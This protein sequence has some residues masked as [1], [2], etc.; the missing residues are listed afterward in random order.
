MREYLSNYYQRCPDFLSEFARED[1]AGRIDFAKHE[2]RF[3]E[4]R[5]GQLAGFQLHAC[6]ASALVDARGTLR[7]AH[8]GL[9]LARRTKDSD[10]ISW[11]ESSIGN[12]RRILEDFEAAEKRLQK[13]RRIA[14]NVVQK[15]DSTRRFAALIFTCAKDDP[16]EIRRALKFYS[17]A[18]KFH[19]AA[20]ERV[21]SDRG[22][23]MALHDQAIAHITLGHQGY[24]SHL[25]QGK[26]DLLQV[27]RE[28]TVHS[29]RSEDGAILNLTILHLRLDQGSPQY[30]LDRL[31][32]S[33]SPKNSLR[34][35]LT[36]WALIFE[37]I[38]AH[39]Y[40]RC[41]RQRLLTVRRHLK[42]EGAW[43]YAS[44]LSLAM[45][46]LEAANE[47]PG[48]LAF[49]QSRETQEILEKGESPKFL[50]AIRGAHQMAPGA[51]V[52]LAEAAGV[53]DAYNMGIRS[54]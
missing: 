48:A 11:G 14:V 40:D 27:L 8:F 1:L 22:Y 6:D 46:A 4:P 16:K 45:A 36:Q 35:A 23:T 9:E 38:R 42:A 24:P 31:E 15:G 2:A 43:N 50:E 19:L 51:I 33:S 5:L 7:A 25:E 29:K 28:A 37:E 39:G 49:L 47:N 26:T 44:Q 54:A 20:P 21:Y 12:L 52:S 13:A 18:L 41:R 32:G 30:L 3:K 17:K 34:G 53:G 10:L